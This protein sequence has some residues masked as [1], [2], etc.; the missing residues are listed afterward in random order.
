MKTLRLIRGIPTLLIVSLLATPAFAGRD[1]VLGCWLAENGGSVLHVKKSGDSIVG[2]IAALNE[3]TYAKGEVEGKDGEIR[4][5]YRN[6]DPAKRDETVLGMNILLDFAWDDG[7]SGKIYDPEGGSIYTAN[8][9][10]ED[11]KLHLRGYIGVSWLG[12][13]VYYVDP[14]TDLALRDELFRISKADGPCAK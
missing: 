12:R 14:K 5:D 9:S 10:F 13:S 6:P 1:D 3:P 11:G 8:L 7:W 2:E 4:R